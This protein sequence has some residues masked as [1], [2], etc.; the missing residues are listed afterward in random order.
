MS[1]K[2]IVCL[3]ILS[4]SAFPLLIAAQS[5]SPAPA[6][7]SSNSPSTSANIQKRVEDYLRYLYGWDNSVKVSFAEAESTG[8]PEIEKLS[9]TVTN[10]GQS[11]TAIVF[12]SKDGKFMFRGEMEDLTSDPLAAIR[13]QISLDDSP[14]R[15]PADAKKVVV[16]YA[17][18]QCP[19]CRTADLNLREILPKYPDFRLVF[20]DFPLVDIHPW[21][22]TAAIAGR[23]AY[24]QS[25]DGFWKLHDLI[26]DNQ[27]LIS[28]VN[29]YDK[30]QEY[31]AQA[32]LD[33]GTLR[34]CM[35]DPKS[36]AAV[37]KSIA[38][39]QRLQVT[40][41]PTLFIN[42][43]RMIGLDPPTFAHQLN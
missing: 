41:T 4:A 9:V 38:E 42:G 19:I 23:C 29:V 36:Q 3:A 30:M 10:A 16:E 2:K 17:D 12:V 18:F 7:K 21:A 8:M 15:G 11:E 13:A 1:I 26:Y 39:G 33:A 27:G 28:T 22:M 6:L 14:S 25:G 20:K 24:Q 31:A 43:R 35:S 37:A 5:G 40:S 34:G 32:G